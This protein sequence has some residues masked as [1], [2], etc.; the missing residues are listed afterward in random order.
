MNRKEFLKRLGMLTVGASL[1]GVDMK[2]LAAEPAASPSPTPNKNVETLDYPIRSLKPETD[3]P[4]SVIIIGAGSRGKTYAKFAGMYP[5]SMKIVGVADLN[6][7]RRRSMAK[8][9]NVPEENCFGDFHDVFKRE[10]FADAVVIATPDNLHYEPCMT[11]L[12]MGYD[13]LLEKPAAQTEKECRAI[14]K[15]AKKYNRIVAICHVLRY[16]PYFV[17]MRQ[18][19]HSGEIGKL[20]S[21]QHQEP[22]QYAH[23][24]GRAHV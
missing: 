15:Q 21:I 22:I 7:F 3:R 2:A 1:I 11:A 19:V 20:V 24:I 13:V 10:K 14:L 16:A 9:Y 17:A 6:T 12:A 23:K 8:L 4:V 18:A 5:E